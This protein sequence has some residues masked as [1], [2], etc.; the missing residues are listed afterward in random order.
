MAQQD[1]LRPRRYERFFSI[2]LPLVLA[3]AVF[4]FTWVSIS[5]SR[6]DSLKLLVMQ[7]TSFTEA[8]ALSAANAIEAESFYDLLVQ[9]RY[10]DIVVTLSGLVIDDRTNDHLSQAA[11]QHELE[12]VYLC[13]L[14][15]GIMAFGGP[16]GSPAALPEFVVAEVRQLSDSLETNYVLLLEPGDLQQPS[17]HYYLQIAN[18]LDRIIVLV[19]D[20]QYY[21]QALQRTQI[22]YLVQ[23][24]SRE[25]GVEYIIYQSTDGIVFA[26]RRTG[27]LLA[28]ESDPFLQ[29]SLNADTIRH[30]EYVFQDRDILELVRPF[31]TTEYPFG[32]FRVG[33]ALDRY[34]TVSRGFDRLMIALATVLMVVVL[35]SL[36]YYSSR[37]K[38]RE[39]RRRYTDIKSITDTIFDQMRTGV[40]AIDETGMLTLANR[41]FERIVG[42]GRVVGRSWDD[43]IKIPAIS[44]E[45]LLSWKEGTDE[46]EIPIT[47][48]RGER[49]LMVAVSEYLPG[50]EVDAGQ[51]VVVYDITRLKEFERKS[52]RRE[53]L[54]EMGNLAAGVAHEIRNPL[55]TISI[56]AQRLAAEFEPPDKREEFI[57]FTGQI[58]AETKRLNQIIT[59]F[60]DLTRVKTATPKP[61]RI[62]AIVSETVD[63]FKLEAD[64]LAIDLTADT[65]AD[66]EVRA[67]PDAI[68]QVLTNLF[69]NAREALDGQP[70]R[71]QITVSKSGRGVKIVFEDSGPGIPPELREKVLTPYF[72]TKDSG[73]GLG[74]PT[75]DR[76][77]TDLGGEV[78]IE[79]SDLGGAKFVILL[80]S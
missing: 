19:V 63:F 42:T 73:T 58:R 78:R 69:T 7:G 46:R 33:L 3:A 77:V 24:M 11:I 62:D 34:Y 60:L 41:A 75:V 36:A 12:A 80:S 44:R 31:A 70:G 43:V 48:G 49:I 10:S 37:R 57:A 15:G 47:T 38:R 72:T 51:V 54:S 40:A 25:P 32:L 76:I 13:D 45:R 14:D 8:L 4:V 9:M 53:R 61:V 39:L 64:T 66:L 5:E 2:V 52:A 27:P 67:D 50:R 29:E 22:G 79:A 1:T 17:L 59:R 74:L 65:E 35:L 56:A 71:I 6:K 28:V 23:D 68:K 20:A 26:S 21:L 16:P 30:R 18:T 55:N